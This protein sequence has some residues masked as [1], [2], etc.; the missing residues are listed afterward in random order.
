MVSIVCNGMGKKRKGSAG[1]RRGEG[2]QR[3]GC[4]EGGGTGGQILEG[5]PQSERGEL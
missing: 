5:P 3:G 4:V 1:E 2:N